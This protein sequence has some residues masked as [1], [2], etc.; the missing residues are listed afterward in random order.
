MDQGWVAAMFEL[1]KKK[2]PKEAQNAQQKASAK[3]NLRKE[4]TSA[5]KNKIL[6]EMS[7]KFL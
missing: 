6:V 4:P 7:K 2:I 5:K 3:N 1:Y